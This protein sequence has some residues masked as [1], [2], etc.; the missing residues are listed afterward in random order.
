MRMTEAAMAKRLDWERANLNR[1]KK[2]STADELEFMERDLA[3]R[4]LP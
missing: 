1:K 3:S 4:W 2:H